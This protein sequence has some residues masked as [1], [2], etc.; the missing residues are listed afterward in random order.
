M[1]LDVD[2]LQQLPELEA[3]LLTEEQGC[4]AFASIITCPR[5]TF[6]DS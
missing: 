3:N 6:D 5:F 1:P 4:C 2:A